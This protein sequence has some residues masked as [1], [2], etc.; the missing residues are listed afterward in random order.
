MPFCDLSA[1]EVRDDILCSHLG[2]LNI[3][4]P[5]FSVCILPHT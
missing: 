1:F 4:V 3:H 2:V 5:E